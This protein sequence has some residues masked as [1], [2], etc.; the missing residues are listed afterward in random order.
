MCTAHKC[1][2]AL[3]VGNVFA[4]GYQSPNKSVAEAPLTDVVRIVKDP[5]ALHRHRPY[6]LRVQQIV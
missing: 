4:D 6:L 1:Q 2:C 3:A 5:R